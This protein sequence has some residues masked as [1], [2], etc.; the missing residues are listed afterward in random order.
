[1]WR[2]RRELVLAFLPR[3]LALGVGSERPGFEECLTELFEIH[4]NCVVV[5]VVVRHGGNWNFSNGRG[6]FLLRGVHVSNVL[7]SKN[8][9][10]GSAIGRDATENEE[11]PVVR[12]GSVNLRHQT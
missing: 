5:V 1:M 3:F 9:P 12:K 11:S 10:S 2:R 7:K 4:V 6:V 8:A